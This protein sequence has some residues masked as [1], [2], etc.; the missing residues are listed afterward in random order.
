MQNIFTAAALVLCVTASAHGQAEQ[1]QGGLTGKWE[2]QTPNGASLLLA[3]TATD[4]TV[5]GTV[6]RNDETSPITDGKVSKNTFSFKATLGEQTEA[7]S[8]EWTGDQITI[9]LDRQGR[10]RAVILKRVKS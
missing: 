4:T 2:G 9:W 3:L 7:L 10:D 6:T 5:T 8:G 1:G